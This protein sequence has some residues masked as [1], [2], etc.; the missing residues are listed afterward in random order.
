MLGVVLK[1]VIMLSGV[2][3]S[4]VAPYQLE[5]NAELLINGPAKENWPSH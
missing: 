5:Y 2:V 4:V 3:P 1:S